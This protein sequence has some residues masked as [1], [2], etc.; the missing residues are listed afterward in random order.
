MTAPGAVTVFPIDRTTTAKYATSYFDDP[1]PR[2]LRFISHDRPRNREASQGSTWCAWII[3]GFGP[4]CFCGSPQIQ[5][6]AECGLTEV[7]PSSHLLKNQLGK[8]ANRIR[9]QLSGTRSLAPR[10]ACGCSVQTHSHGGSTR[11]R[12][13]GTRRRCCR[14]DLPTGRPGCRRADPVQFH[15]N[16]LIEPALLRPP[17][18][19]HQPSGYRA[20]R[21][22]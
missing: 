16:A 14:R 15:N 7:F 10:G 6:G 9:T 19:A 21:F 18:V 12:P 1:R 22:V 11:R 8:H 13:E 5:S 17:R 3:L 2:W 4:I 20:P